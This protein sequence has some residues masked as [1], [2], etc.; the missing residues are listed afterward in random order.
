[1]LNWLLNSKLL[2]CMLSE[3][4]MTGCPILLLWW[5]IKHHL[6]HLMRRHLHRV[7]ILIPKLVL[8]HAHHGRG[9]I[10]HSDL[11]IKLVL[12]SWGWGVLQPLL[13]WL[14]SLFYQLRVV[15]LVLVRLYWVR[16]RMEFPLWS[17]YLYYILV[18]MFP[19]WKAFARSLS[20]VLIIDWYLHH[21]L[22]IHGLNIASGTHHAW[23]HAHT[24][25]HAHFLYILRVFHGLDRPCPSIK[26]ILIIVV[27]RLTSL[28]VTG[29]DAYWAFAFTQMILHFGAEKVLVSV[30]RHTGPGLG[31]ETLTSCLPTRIYFKSWAW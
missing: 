7:Y 3:S 20:C 8:G 31:A 16:S 4:W 9:A 26:S 18:W 2:L 12:E 6:R 23:L 14:V 17:L 21:V 5:L 25:G 27:L 11:L 28:V 15:P 22:M 19:F 24:H 29:F 30:F 10:L 13:G 1:M